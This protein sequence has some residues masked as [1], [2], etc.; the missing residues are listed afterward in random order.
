MALDHDGQAQPISESQIRTYPQPGPLTGQPGG[1][2]HRHHPQPALLR[3]AGAMCGQ[4][5]TCR[6]GPSCSRSR[7]RLVPPCPGRAYRDPIDPQVTAQ[8]G[9]RR[10]RACHRGCWDA[11][12]TPSIFV[13]TSTRCSRP[14]GQVCRA[15]RSLQEVF[16]V[17]RRHRV[18]SRPG[19]IA[20]LRAKGRDAR[21]RAAGGSASIRPPTIRQRHTPT[22]A[23]P[24]PPAGLPVES[25]PSSTHRGSHDER[26][27]PALDVTRPALTK[28]YGR[29]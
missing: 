3:P 12:A 28:R 14:Q 21:W 23:A 4:R 29:N 1:T 20:G 19:S 6:T 24:S 18:W 15:R 7:R 9:P 25:R 27:A 13:S 26:A 22:T 11:E 5:S 2:P 8:R 16:L 10:R 17:P